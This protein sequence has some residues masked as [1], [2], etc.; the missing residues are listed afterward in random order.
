MN[1]LLVRSYEDEGILDP[2]RLLTGDDIMSRFGLKEG[3]IV[4]RVLDALR[5]AQG[6]GEVTDRAQAWEFVAAEIS[7]SGGDG[8][9]A[10]AE[11]GR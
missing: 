10:E 11:Q 7:S 4:G 8:G 1:G 2:P 5:E 6:A 3:P 9:A